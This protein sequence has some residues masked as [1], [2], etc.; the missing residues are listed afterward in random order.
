[1]LILIPVPSLAASIDN[2]HMFSRANCFNFNES[3]SWDSSL[4]EW[5]MATYSHH[6]NLATFESEV[7]YA[8]FEDTS[9]SYAG[10]GPAIAESQCNFN[11][12]V[13][14][15]EHYITTDDNKKEKE[16]QEYCDSS[17]QNVGETPF[18][19]CRNTVAYNC[20]L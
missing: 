18:I 11:A 17:W 10:C 5:D 7:Y 12:S 9:R 20:N 4:K 15:G 8:F 3:I 13:V 2:L 16:L 6:Y 1:M 14:Y 19:A